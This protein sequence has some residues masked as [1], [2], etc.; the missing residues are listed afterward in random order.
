M[1]PVLNEYGTRCSVV[2]N[3]DFDFGVNHEYLFLKHHRLF[4]SCILNYLLFLLVLTTSILPLSLGSFFSF[5]LVSFS[6]S[7]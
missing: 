4:Y 2:G 3:H 5:L 7:G 1:V 6:P